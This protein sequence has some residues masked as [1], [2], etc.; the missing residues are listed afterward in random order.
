M[1]LFES[2]A[3]VQ[4]IFLFVDLDGRFPRF[5]LFPFLLFLLI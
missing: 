2:R 3:T 4:G 5:F 1:V